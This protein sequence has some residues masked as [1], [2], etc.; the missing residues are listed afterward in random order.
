MLDVRLR[1]REA[2]IE[3]KFSIVKRLL[4]RFPHYLKN[5]DSTNGWSSLHYAGFHGHYI[6]CVYLVNA[7]H[8]KN[9]IS[10]SFNDNAPVHTTVLSG[11]HQTLLMILQSFPATLDLKGNKLQTPLHMASVLDYSSCVKLLIDKGAN[12]NSIDINGNTPLHLAMMNGSQESIV[13]LLKS[14]AYFDIRN[15][16]GW[17]PAEC[18][19]DSQTEK[20]FNLCKTEILNS[21][22][23]QIPQRLVSETESD[24]SFKGSNLFS[25]YIAST[26]VT[27]TPSVISG[28]AFNKIHRA[29][30]DSSGKNHFSDNDEVVSDFNVTYKPQI[31][32]SQEALT[33]TKH[34]SNA[35][36]MFHRSNS[37]LGNI[38]DVSIE[39]ESATPEKHS[40]SF[41]DAFKNSSNSLL[42]LLSPVF[43]PSIPPAPSSHMHSPNKIAVGSPLSGTIGLNQRST[44]TTPVQ[45]TINFSTTTRPSRSNSNDVYKLRVQQPN[46]QYK[47]IHSNS[48]GAFTQNYSQYLNNSRSNNNLS[49]NIKT[50]FPK[51]DTQ[52]PLHNTKSSTSLSSRVSENLIEIP[53][54][55]TIHNK[56]NTPGRYRSSTLWSHNSV[57]SDSRSKLSTTSNTP[58]STNFRQDLKTDFD[59]ATALGSEAQSPLDNPLLM[60]DDDQASYDSGTDLDSSD[61]DELAASGTGVLPLESPEKANPDTPTVTEDTSLPGYMKG[62][63]NTPAHSELAKFYS[64]AVNDNSHRFDNIDSLA[65]PIDP[66]ETSTVNPFLDSSADNETFSKRSSV[67]KVP[68]MSMLSRRKLDNE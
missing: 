68:I 57:L 61:E 36:G 23:R 48:V 33:K 15:A 64:P 56:I 10:T 46:N 67:L 62:V 60:S 7:G 52:I 26:G 16:D 1:L 6:I 42:S 34:T 41:V 44:S 21:T 59:S 40:S 29:D 47:R 30:L 2:V 28:T 14:N 17:L 63:R 50:L 43:P 27:S 4:L 38:A 12:V 39:E 65:S 24:G 5:I 13:S 22:A 20:C 18:A 9:E 49:D 31:P 35:A 53:K 11:N 58:R 3:G 54:S 25:S 32:Q 45:Q 66:N 55:D 19:R 8:D 37:V 51:S